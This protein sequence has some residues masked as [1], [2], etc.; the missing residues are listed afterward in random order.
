MKDCDDFGGN[1]MPDETGDG[2]GNGF[3]TYMDGTKA[4]KQKQIEVYLERAG[5]I[6]NAY[7]N[8]KPGENPFP[9]HPSGVIYWE[10]EQA[11][12]QLN[13][14]E[15]LGADVSEQRERVSGIAARVSSAPLNSKGKPH[16]W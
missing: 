12:V 16:N 7:E 1:T 14:A 5:G 15:N 3:D 4:K 9:P 6:L 13:R 2:D 8:A 10:L 11:R